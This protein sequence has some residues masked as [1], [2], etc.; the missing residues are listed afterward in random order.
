MVNDGPNCLEGPV[1]RRS[2][3]WTAPAAGDPSLNAPAI[4]NK[5]EDRPIR[6]ELVERVRREIAEGT[7]D[8]P[9][10]WEVALERLFRQFD[11]D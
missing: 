5:D 1:S 11:K 4:A 8:T 10:R 6:R 3:W 2:P 9:E 7:Y